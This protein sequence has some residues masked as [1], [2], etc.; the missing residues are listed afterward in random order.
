[1]DHREIGKRLDLW[2]FHPFSPGCPIWL[3]KGNVVYSLLSD[4]IRELNRSNGYME[5][6]TPLHARG[7]QEGGRAVF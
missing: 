3:P 2:M 7:G 1:M 5:V 4:R 6:R